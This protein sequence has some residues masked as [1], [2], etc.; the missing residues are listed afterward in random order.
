MRGNLI[1]QVIF[2]GSIDNKLKAKVGLLKKFQNM[3]L[4]AGNEK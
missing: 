2:E 4:L 1:Y 3:R